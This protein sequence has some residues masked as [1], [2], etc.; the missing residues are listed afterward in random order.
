[1]FLRNYSVSTKCTFDVVHYW[2]YRSTVQYICSLVWLCAMHVT[3]MNTYCWLCDLAHG[4]HGENETL[5]IV[6]LPCLNNIP[7]VQPSTYDALHK[8]GEQKT[9]TTRSRLRWL[10]TQFGQRPWRTG[11]KLGHNCSLCCEARIPFQIILM[12]RKLRVLIERNQ[13]C[14]W[15]AHPFQ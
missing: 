12:E 7:G 13:L 5:R 4:T 9:R 14:E 1:M 15:Q 6:I 11:I 2:I 8:C 3:N 10:R